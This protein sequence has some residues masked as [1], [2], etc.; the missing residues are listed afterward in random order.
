MKP[1]MTCMF[2]SFMALVSWTTVEAKKASNTRFHWYYYDLDTSVNVGGQSRVVIDSKGKIKVAYRGWNNL[3]YSEFDGRNWTTVEADTAVYG[4]SKVDLA[5]DKDDHPH[6]LFQD[7]DY[8]YTLHSWFDGS[9]WNRHQLVAKTNDP[10]KDFYQLAIGSNATGEIHMA[11]TVADTTTVTGPTMQWSVLG[12]DNKPSVAM[13][14][15]NRGRTGKWNSMTFDASGSPVITYYA[16]DHSNLA[17]AYRENGEWK[18]QVIDSG[19]WDHSQGFYPW[20]EK[21]PRSDSFYI[22]FKSTAKNTLRLAK[23]NPKTGWD[24][25]T[26][27]TNEYYTQFSSTNPMSLDSKGRIYIAH[28]KIHYSGKTD[29]DS[30]DNSRLVL[31]YRL[32]STWFHEVV[33]TTLLTGQ[34]ASIALTSDSLPVITYFEASTRTMKMAI[35]S[36]EAPAD[37]NSNGIPDY[38]EPVALK[39]AMYPRARIF[40]PTGKS[41]DALGKERSNTSQVEESISSRITKRV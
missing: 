27:D 28:P 8:L 5:L 33:D 30:V 19:D 18:D 1:A 23:G 24:T 12:S 3:K 7:W 17:V 35:A 26:I 11:Y 22:A 21:D 37:T 10:N 13:P 15:C 16:F 9:K 29:K 38:Q 39:R 25:S 34:Y 14:I 6:L 36:L 4:A 31:T 2:I 32:D 40:V 41:Y 20:I